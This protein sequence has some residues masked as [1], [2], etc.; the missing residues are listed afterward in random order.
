MKLMQ[1]TERLDKFSTPIWIT[2]L[3]DHK[4]LNKEL[5]AYVYA[6]RKK[7]P[8]G[9]QRSNM[10]GWHSQNIIIKESKPHMKF[11]KKILP[12]IQTVME[13]MDWDSENYGVKIKDTWAIINQQGACNQ[14]HIHGNNLISAAY[15]VN[16][17]KKNEE[18]YGGRIV[19]LDPRESNLFYK[20]Y[21]RNINHLNEQQVTVQP[22]T[23]VLAMFPSYVYHWVEPN[24]SKEDR[25]ILSFNLDQYSFSS[26]MIDPKKV[27]IIDPKKIS[28]N[29]QKILIDPKRL[30]VNTKNK[31]SKVSS[32]TRKYIYRDLF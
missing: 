28:I 3:E 15:Y 22:K 8:I 9:R 13:D 21:T 17:P 11:F 24:L 4:E 12:V 16:V 25:V 1:K 30:T 32:Q 18:G 31:Q 2:R 29:P 19:F 20:P 26:A 5:L 27:S 10:L 6:L 14:S 7:D 23:G